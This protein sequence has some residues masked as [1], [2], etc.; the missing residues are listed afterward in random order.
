[1]SNVIHSIDRAIK[2][3]KFQDKYTVLFIGILD[4]EKMTIRYVNASMSDPIIVTR[5]PEGYRIKPLSSNCS[6]IGIIDLDNVVVAE[7]KLFRGDLI[8]MASDGISEAMD[9]DGVELGT[10]DTY[11]TTIKNSANKSAGSFV[12]DLANLVLSHSGG[13]LRDDVTMLVAKVEG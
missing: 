1:M 3:M 11:L 4:T 10:T 5:S 9:K 12:S 8:L 6:L 13:H 2:D 7:Q